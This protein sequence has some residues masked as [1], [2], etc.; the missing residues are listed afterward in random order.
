LT[1]KQNTCEQ[2]ELFMQ[3]NL[4]WLQIGAGCAWHYVYFMRAKQLAVTCAQLGGPVIEGVKH[5]EDVVCFS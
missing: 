3:V 5:Q 4:S 1:D 2:I